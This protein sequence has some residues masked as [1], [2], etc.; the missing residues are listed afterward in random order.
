MTVAA[1]DAVTCSKKRA[2]DTMSSILFKCL[3]KI[4]R[5]GIKKN[6]KQIF[7]NK[8]TGHRFIASS[9]NAKVAENWLLSKLQIEKLKQKID[10]PIDCDINAKFIFYFPKSVYFTKKGLRSRKLPDLDNL[11]CLPLDCLQKSKIIL[12]DSIVCSLD[13]TKRLPING[14][15]HFLEIII[16][17]YEDEYTN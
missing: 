6:S 1:L 8:K 17:R 4:N 9:N 15:D 10:S 11:I 5:H 3:I 14:T 13:G 2:K 12:D 7:M 16:S